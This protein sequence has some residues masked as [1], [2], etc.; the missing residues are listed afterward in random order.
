[1]ETTRNTTVEMAC[2]QCGAPVGMPALAD[3][4]VCSYCGSV[5]TRGEATT[6]PLA[7]PEKQTLRS[8]QC[9]QCAGPLDAFEGRRILVCSH[10]GVRV[11]VRPHHG[12]S[13]WIFPVRFDRLQAAHQAATWLREY[14]GIARDARNAHFVEAKL[15]YAPIWEHKALVAGWEFGRK[16]RTRAEPVAAQFPALFAP[17]YGE[18]NVQLELQMVEEAVKEPRLQER[19]YYQAATDFSVLDATR[20]RVTGREL[21]LPLLAGELDPSAIVLEAEGT[22]DEVED[23]GRRIALQP[24]SGAISPETHLFAFR[25]STSLLYYPLWLVRFQQGNR[26]SRVVVSGRNGVVN[27]GIAPAGNARRAALLAVQFGVLAIVVAILAWLAS[28]WDSGRISMIAAA[29]I[30]S[31]GAIALAWRFRTVGEVEYHEP[32]SN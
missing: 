12:F 15:V 13:R 2:P 18:E 19:R 10:C 32:F 11:A 4:A 14:P 5:L 25:E 20:P 29:V 9:T 23:T 24:V 26:L 17:A 21:L 8:V 28:I 3:A 31:L 16:L 27:S 7:A 22:A 30:V 1:M 6:V